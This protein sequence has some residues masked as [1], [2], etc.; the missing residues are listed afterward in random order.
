MVFTRRGKRWTASEIFEGKE[1]YIDLISHLVQN[2]W[3][4]IRSC[5]F[6][7]VYVYA[8]LLSMFIKTYEK[9][10]LLYRVIINNSMRA[11]SAHVYG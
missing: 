7:T 9:I 8:K 10:Y 11:V 2:A 5:W 4:K 1:Y 3:F 6:L